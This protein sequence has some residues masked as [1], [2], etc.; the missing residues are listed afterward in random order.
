MLKITSWI[1]SHMPSSK[2]DC[3]IKDKSCLDSMQDDAIQKLKEG[4]R[5]MMS[6]I[7]AI[8]AKYHNETKAG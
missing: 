5:F 8:G 1:E 4:R 2:P 6:A 3:R 7:D